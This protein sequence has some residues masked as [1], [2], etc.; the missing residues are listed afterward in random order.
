MD[1]PGGS[2][3]KV[4]AYIA[5]DPGSIPGSGR[6]PGEGNG[7]PLQ[8]S[9][10]ENPTDRGIW[11]ATV[12]GVAKS[13]TQLSDFTF[14][15]FFLLLQS[16]GPSAGASVVGAHGLSCSKVYEIFPDQGSIPCPLHGQVDSL[17][18]DHQKSPPVFSRQ[19]LLTTGTPALQA[20][21]SEARNVSERRV[22]S[23]NWVSVGLGLYSQPCSHHCGWWDIIVFV[24][25]TWK[26]KRHSTPEKN[27]WKQRQ[28]PDLPT[29]RCP[30]LDLS[31]V[32]A[33]LGS[34]LSGQASSLR[35]E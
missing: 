28:I 2:D 34:I 4:S 18:L 21:V 32:S 33:P 9:C 16:T 17:S 19:D 23:S 26:L 6:S 35:L 20:Y 30:I 15:P 1:F 3:G 8:Y 29:S 24:C 13:R 31:S 7:N 14:F 27:H 25:M 12:H 10:L 11:W 22:N 5:G